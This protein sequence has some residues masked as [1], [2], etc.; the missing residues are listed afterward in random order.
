MKKVMMI[1]VAVFMVTAMQAQEKV[2]NSYIDNGGDV[3]EATLYHEDGSISQTGFFT[4]DGKITGE[5]ISYDRQGREMAKAQYENGTKVGTWFFWNDNALSRVTYI[6]SNI[7]DVKTW[8]GEN[9]RVVS[10]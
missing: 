2:K 6:D 3:I 8:E 4:K 5:W 10:K 9:V 7:I 1:M